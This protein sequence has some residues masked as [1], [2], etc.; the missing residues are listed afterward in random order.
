MQG[1]MKF[2]GL[3]EEA[4]EQL[5][6]DDFEVYKKIARFF[7]DEYDR[8]EN[9]V[10]LYKS[11]PKKGKFKAKIVYRCLWGSGGGASWYERIEKRLIVASSDEIN[12]PFILERRKTVGEFIVL[13]YDKIKQSTNEELKSYLNNLLGRNSKS[14]YE[15]KIKNVCNLLRKRYKKYNCTYESEDDCIYIYDNKKV[16]YCIKCKSYDFENKDANLI[17]KEIMVFLPNEIRNLLYFQEN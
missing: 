16:D 6:E 17:F 10:E 1:G 12:K 3:Q 8:C 4:K 13:D 14:F 5:S 11:K 9:F 15:E 7:V 2:Y